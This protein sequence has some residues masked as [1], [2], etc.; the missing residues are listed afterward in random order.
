MKGQNLFA[1]TVKFNKLRSVKSDSL[2]CVFRF[3]N[4]DR[5]LLVLTGFSETF[6]RLFGMVLKPISRAIDW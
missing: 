2:W 1:L 6:L 5:F 4:F 3:L